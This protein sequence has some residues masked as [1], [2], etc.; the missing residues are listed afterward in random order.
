MQKVNLFILSLSLVFNQ[1]FFALL[2]LAG[3]EY[4]GSEDSSIF[5]ICVIAINAYTIGYVCLNELFKPKNT[6]FSKTVYLL[7]I[8]LAL[9][10]FLEFNSLLDPAGKIFRASMAFIVGPIFATHYVMRNNLL[11][12]VLKNFDIIMILCT[13]GLV[14]NI[15]TMVNSY[16]FTHIAG[17]GGHQQ[18]SYSSALC[19]G[20]NL[21]GLLNADYVERY[22]IFKTKIARY[23][24]ILL[25]FIQV[26]VV[27]ISGG[28][29]GLVLLSFEAFLVL[30]LYTKISF[31]TLITYSLVGA[32]AFFLFSAL[33]DNNFFSGFSDSIERTFSF[34]SGDGISAGEERNSVYDTVM[35]QVE[36][37]PIIG[38][39]FWNA[40][41]IIAPLGIIYSHNIFLDVLLQGG[42]VFLFIFCVFYFRLC[43]RT[44]SIVKTHP[45]LSYLIPLFSYP[46]V[47]LI[48]STNYLQESLFWF[49]II[50]VFFD[51]K[52]FLQR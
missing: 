8:I 44:V 36:N 1:V 15:P 41:N 52:Y 49:W 46:F 17:G 50:I 32:I 34:I 4:T 26:V 9:L 5:T 3:L 13:L 38:Y 14:L 12:Q 40:Y 43:K 16:G 10:F 20:I 42:I 37:S 45:D 19:F 51:Y 23:I 33:S 24:S 39:G 25:L 11:P 35:K 18:I 2:S 21:C 28:R 22:S 29:G 6:A 47:E 31:K 48:I 30:F 27:A 7:P